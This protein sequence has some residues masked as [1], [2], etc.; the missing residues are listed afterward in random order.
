MADNISITKMKALGYKCLEANKGNIKAFIKNE[1]LI[2]I[3]DE[4]NKR[5]KFKCRNKTTINESID[6][7]LYIYTPYGYSITLYNEYSV[8]VGVMYYFRDYDI[9]DVNGCMKVVGDFLL[10]KNVSSF[11]GLNEDYIY[12]LANEKLYN[13]WH[14]ELVRLGAVNKK[15]NIRMAGG[16]I[17]ID[18]GT[19]WQVTENFLVM[20]E[21]TWKGKIIVKGEQI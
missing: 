11:N 1:E 18:T 5:L 2:L 12:D 17:Y 14:D 19:G 6:R 16:K 13:I 4:N 3:I 8:V 7:M 10:N 21:D 9:I 15:Y 20:N